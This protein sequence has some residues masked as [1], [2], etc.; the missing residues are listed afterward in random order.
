MPEF[1][2]ETDLGKYSINAADEK[3]AME[4]L[5]QEMGKERAAIARADQIEK[6]QGKAG[7]SDL[8][9][10]SFSFGLEDK[11]AGVVGGVQG[12]FN[13]EGF[14][15]GF[16]KGR[17]AQQIIEERARKRSGKLG[18]VAEVAGSVGTGALFKA[19]A[20]ASVVGRIFQGGKEG[21]KGA[22]LFGA[23][24]SDANTLQEFAGDVG[25]ST[26]MGAGFGSAGSGLFEAGRG[27][28]KGGVAIK[29]GLE[30]VGGGAK[31]AAAAKIAKAL[32]ADGTNVGAATARMARRDTPLINAGGD[33]ENLVR[34]GR[35]VSS[36]PGKGATLINRGLD[37]Q[38][39]GA[40][41]KGVKIAGQALGGDDMAFAQRVDAMKAGRMA[42]AAP[43]YKASWKSGL[44]QGHEAELRAIIKKTPKSALD[45]AQKI[46]ASKGEKLA[47]MPT[48][49]QFHYIQMGLRQVTDQSF[50]SSARTLGS[51]YKATRDELMSILK[52]NKNYGM[53]TKA[54][55]DD[56][57]LEEALQAGRNIL[58]PASTRNADKLAMDFS[59][60][61]AGEKD[62]YK[63]GVAR[64]I[65][66][67]IQQVPS[68]AGNLVKRIF[69]SPAK[70][71]AIRS[72]FDSNAEFRAFQ[73]EIQKVAKEA[74]SF[75]MVRTGS[76]TS[77]VDAERA[78][79]GA[80]ADAAQG[81][82]DAL[83]NPASAA[84][85][86]FVGIVRNM[87]GMNE[88]VAVEAAKLLM[89]KDPALVRAALAKNVSA[90][91]RQDATAALLTK[92]RSLARG[93][94]A[95]GAGSVAVPASE[96]FSR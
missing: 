5:E 17:R 44:P 57:A 39:R 53:A 81:T 38:Q 58:K 66:D 51:N 16:D 11:A 8:F 69:G 70:R 2:V 22:A 18:T 56:I 79:G 71:A 29:R 15:G 89:S 55:A 24:E 25:T 72:A 61:S 78:A 82:A 7:A 26:L 80:L 93:A 49:Q 90:R 88:D 42:K 47:E 87:G 33:G 4:I 35:G 86:G 94:T 52:K 36:T 21:A 77:F 13:G 48:M 83:T 84:F 75:S 10:N 40:A 14:G 59:K 92:V 1:E 95:G 45:A 6:V 46:A 64:A 32:D 9:R 73:L 62:L 68:E 3:A 43:L 60:M 34:L 37:A 41:S 30:G 28:Y 74:K 31:E 50:D 91:A 63:M 23:G 19:P 54:Y 12:L 20:A 65:Q 76:R 96:V 67:E 27:L 85:R